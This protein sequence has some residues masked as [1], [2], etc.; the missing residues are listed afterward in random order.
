MLEFLH[1]LGLL[2]ALNR[3][4]VW[5]TVFTG[6]VVAGLTATY[7]GLSAWKGMVIGVTA[8]GA[9]AMVLPW[10]HPLWAHIAVQGGLFGL[11]AGTSVHM[12]WIGIGVV[13]AVVAAL[14]GGRLSA[15]IP[16]T[17]WVVCVSAAAMF[18]THH[19]VINI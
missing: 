17:I 15:S 3:E 4:T 9:A 7:T 13:S 2:I 6:I 14:V 16:E 8:I 12:V 5:I 19:A 1:T 18:A 11:S 10:I